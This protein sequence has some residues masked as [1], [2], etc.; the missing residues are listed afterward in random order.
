[1]L[2]SH[3]SKDKVFRGDEEMEI[4]F[5]GKGKVIGHVSVSDALFLRLA[6][7][8]FSKIGQS[9]PTPMVLD[10]E[11]IKLPLVRLTKKIRA[12]LQRFVVCFIAEEV[13]RLLEE[14]GTRPTGREVEP[15]LNDLRALIQIA[16]LLSNGSVIYLQRVP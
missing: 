13:E 7:S 15:A 1:V 2:S 3:P 12:M 10:Q 4:S 14:H 9:R 16:H 11:R 5:Y 6:R 8:E